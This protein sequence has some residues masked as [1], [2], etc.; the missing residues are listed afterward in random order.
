ML[1]ELELPDPDCIVSLPAGTDCVHA[2]LLCSEPLRTCQRN[3]FQC[4]Q[5]ALE[6]L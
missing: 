6:G 2:G 3:N 5:R 1:Q 4:I